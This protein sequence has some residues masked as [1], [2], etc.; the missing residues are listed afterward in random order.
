MFVLQQKQQ[1]SLEVLQIQEEEEEEQ[2]G[3]E[4]YFNIYLIISFSLNV[5]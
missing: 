5:F 2:Q 3:E 1:H 4:Q